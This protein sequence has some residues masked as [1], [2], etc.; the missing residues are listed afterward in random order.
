M[1][2][3]FPFTRDWVDLDRFMDRVVQDTLGPT[4]QVW[5]RSNTTPQPMPV[6]IYA[7]DDAAVVLAALPGVRPDDLDLSIHQ[8]TVTI[9]GKIMSAVDSEEARGATWLNREFWSGEFRRSFTLPFAVNPDRVDAT[10]D[11]GILKITLPKAEHA[12]PQK[13][14]IG[15]GQPQPQSIAESSTGN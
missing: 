2:T 12:K 3:A 10:F 8:N 9:S 15:T 7:T 13:I 14:S 1:V 6:D 4:R 11:Q 5:S